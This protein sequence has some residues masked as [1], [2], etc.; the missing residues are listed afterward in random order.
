MSQTGPVKLSTE[1]L[2]E[3]TR[4]VAVER[5][6]RPLTP[7]QVAAIDGSSGFW[8]LADSGYVSVRR[9]GATRHEIVG[10]KYVGRA[11][12]G[13]LEVEV[14]EKV[15]GT[16]QSLIESATG[17][18][19]RIEKTDSPAT[20]FERVSRHLM[21]EFVAATGRYI[22]DRRSPRYEYTLATGPTLSGALDIPGTLRLQAQGRPEQLAYSTGRV[23]RDE[24]LDRV[25][26][27]GLDEVDRSG[28]ALKLGRDTIYDARW[29]A[30]A[31]EGVRDLD[32]LSLHRQDYV[33]VADAIET[34]PETGPDDRDLARLAMVALLHRGFAAEHRVGGEVPRAWFIDLE[35]LFEQAVR[36]VLRSKVEAY[37]VD[38]GKTF[39]RQ[40]FT[41]GLDHSQANPDLV[42]HDG[43]DVAA[44]GDVKYKSLRVP[45]EE[46]PDDEQGGSERKKEGRP[47]LYQVLAHADALSANVAFLVYPSEDSYESRFLG[48]S[49]TGCSTWTVQVRPTHLQEDLEQ[50]ASECLVS[51]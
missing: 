25:A 26:L 27:A 6:R 5:R 11:L 33:A 15:K 28:A 41:G 23:V 4:V 9:S 39:D 1:H 14:R 16:L 20:D 44:V 19:L 31:L 30:G 8:A 47:D 43:T 29:L 37:E 51:S 42:V 48:S 13:G 3:M 35:T 7:E 38:R 50:F 12:T 18:E 34:D 36:E 32:Y 10:H 24:P 2:R 21:Q 46:R 40:M 22:A 17:A 45:F 49:A